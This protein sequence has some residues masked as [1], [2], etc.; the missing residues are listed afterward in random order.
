MNF[1]LLAEVRET[2]VAELEARRGG[3]IHRAVD[4]LAARAT[5]RGGRRGG[6]SLDAG[7][8]GRAG[9]FRFQGA[10]MSE[11]HGRK[12]TR[13]LGVADKYRPETAD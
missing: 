8:T 10:E 11:R 6:D 7:G 9:A 3:F 2:A 13:K 12:A 1:A 5:V 4:G